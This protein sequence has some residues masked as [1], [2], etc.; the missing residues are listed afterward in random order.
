MKQWPRF[1]AERQ[2][3][4]EKEIALPPLN[5]ARKKELAAFTKTIDI[6]FKSLELLNLAFTHRSVSNETPSKRNNE[7]LEFLGDAILG[8]V[9]ATLLYQNLPGKTEGD[10]AKVKAVVVSEDILSGIARELQIDTMLV[11]GHGEALSGGRTKKAIL[12]DALEAL[13]GALYLDSGYKAAVTFISRWISAEIFR[14]REQGYH[15]DYKSLLQ[16][17]CQ[18]RYKKCPEYRMVKQSGPE[19]ERLFWMEV[20]AGGAVF[21]PCMGKNKKSAEQEAARLAYEAID[22]PIV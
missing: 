18:R 2:P 14:V 21:G 16:E 10:L 11:L 5:A 13:F 3:P 7:R 17:T 20:E 8:A 15:K 12:A 19:H 1:M 6:R 4:D 22:Q 9:T